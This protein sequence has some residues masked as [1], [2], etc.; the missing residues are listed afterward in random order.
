MSSLLRNATWNYAGTFFQGVVGLGVVAFTVRHLGMA[1][2]GTL[3]LALTVA[4]LLILLDFGLLAVLTPGLVLHRTRDGAREAGRLAGAAFAACVGLGVLCAVLGGSAALLAPLV[5]GDPDA[6][7]SATFIAATAGAIALVALP[8]HAVARMH[9]ANSNYGLIGRTNV[10]LAVGTAAAVVTVLSVGAGLLGL[11]AVYVGSA[12]ARLLVLL[13]A[14]HLVDRG[15]FSAWLDP[16][17]NALRDVWRP[18][19]WALLD[20][21]ARQLTFGID[22]LVLGTFAT[23]GAVALFG[24]GRRIPFHLWMLV[25]KTVAVVLPVF[26]RH[27]S[28]GDRAALRGLFARTCRMTVAVVLPAA[29]AGI[30]LAGWIVRLWVGDA[31]GG[32]VAPMRWL[33]VTTT[34][35][36]LSVPAITLLYAT[37]EI[38]TS[39]R[40]AAWE[41]LAN[42]GLSL[43]FV[44]K[45]EA[46]GV[47]AATAVTHLVF[48]AAWLL[49]AACRA[50]DLPVA[51]LASSI[52]HDTLAPTVVLLAG[53]AWLLVG[54]EAL[55]TVVFVAGLCTC[56]GAF[57]V[58]WMR[59]DVIRLRGATTASRTGT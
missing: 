9:E 44:G 47:A 45:F 18:G 19:G 42:L 54:P 20:N 3:L 1:D 57:F 30:A 8:A 53:V 21:T 37:G 56:A 25:E 31:Y 41:A 17:W 40:V 43:L 33:L 39:A 29:I 32:A 4:E 16:D 13:V 48:T 10:L 12:V 6:A 59:S 28:T 24:V 58:L 50:A 2:Y 5:I 11:G 15:Q 26:S 46:T 27:Y 22:S 51:D 38:S 7:R 14:H 34:A 52:A 55:P 23:M 35:L 36:A 49:P